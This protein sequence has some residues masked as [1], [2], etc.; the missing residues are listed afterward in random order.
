LERVTVIK[1]RMVNAYLLAGEK[2]CVLV[3]TGVR[4]SEGKILEAAEALGFAPHDIK[5]IILTHGHTDHYGSVQALAEKT[6]AE[7]L[8]HKAEYDLMVKGGVEGL[9]GF[10]FF[11][12]LMVGMLRRVAKSR[13]ETLEYKAD[14]LIEDT[15]DLS[16]Y[17]I[18]GK[19]ICTPGHTPGSVSVLLDDGKVIIGDS[20]MA[21][22]PWSKLGKPLIG[23]DLN[24][25]KTSM[26]K[27]IELGANRFYLSHGSVYDVEIIRNALK[28]F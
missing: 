11:G 15:Y 4:G 19:I 21:M 12:K 24:N 22:M 8:V 18:E 6:G 2:G 9:K 26:N 16:P 28:R 27:L 13:E 17:G 23:Y 1:F 3:D 20:L 14:I 7:V 5:L 10:S 25:I